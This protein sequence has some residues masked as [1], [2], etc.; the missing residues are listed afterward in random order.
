MIVAKGDRAIVGGFS[1][2]CLT[3]RKVFRRLPVSGLVVADCTSHRFR[4]GENTVQ[5]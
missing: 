5:R 3:S 4:S 1:K 2:Q